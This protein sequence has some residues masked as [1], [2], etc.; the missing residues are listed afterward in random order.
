MAP[1]LLQR[2]AMLRSSLFSPLL[3]VLL[4][5]G[6]EA[7]RQL[8][9][10]AATTDGGGTVDGGGAADAGGAADGSVWPSIEGCFDGLAPRQA[11]R[12]VEVLGLRQTPA[13][14][15]LILA[16]E[17]GDRPGA[18]GETWAF[19]L[20]RFALEDAAGNTHCVTNPSALEYSFGHHNWDERARVVIEGR[21]YV[22]TLRYFLNGQAMWVDELSVLDAVSGAV[23]SGPVPLVKEACRSIPTNPNA[24]FAR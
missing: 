10:A 20:V 9:D 3:L 15:R 1:E 19:D 7:V 2:R 14:A 5:C 23:L 22:V 17:P 21:A 12:F 6:G 8:P 11:G 16:R 18:V 24:C 4:C 13:G